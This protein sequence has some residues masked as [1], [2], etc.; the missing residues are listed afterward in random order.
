MIV[1][2]SML[3][4]EAEREV[5][6]RLY[7]ENRQKLYC[8]AW[9]IL[10]NEAD[11]EDAV[12]ICFLKVVDKF[13]RYRHLTYKQLARLC[14]AVVRNAAIDIARENGKKGNY[15]T[16]AYNSENDMFDCGTDILAEIIKQYERELVTQA[17]MQLAEEERDFLMLQYDLGLKPKDIGEL[18]DMSSASV[19]KKMQGCRNK[20]AK[21]LEGEEYEGL[22]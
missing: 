9:K 3:E 11:A 1:Y 18:M 12:H 13:A 6:Q 17:L 16:E 4:T 19:R 8:I 10:R 5:F 7:E 21:I 2:F 22:R 20:V 14:C 15:K